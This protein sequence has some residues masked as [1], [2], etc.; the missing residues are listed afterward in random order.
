[1]LQGSSDPAELPQPAP[2][3]VV[4]RI[5][6]KPAFSMEKELTELE[7]TLKLQSDKPR[8]RI[9][10]FVVEPTSGRYVDLGAHE[11]Y[12]AAS[13]IKLPVLVTL[14]IA[15]DR[16]QVTPKQLLTVRQDLVAGG[17]GY[18]QWRA[19][20]SQV[21]LAEAAELMMVNSDNTATNLIIDLLGG[22]DVLNRQFAALGLKQTRINN[23]LPD[24]A[25]TNKTSPF[26]LAYLL[27]VADNGGLISED[28]KSFMFRLMERT[29]T[30]TLL[31]PGLGIGAK[32][33]HKTGDIGGMVGDA[34]IV[35]APSGLRYIVVGQV[36]RPHNDRRANEL[37]RTMSR[38]IYGAFVPD[39]TFPPEETKRAISHVHSRKH[40]HKHQRRRSL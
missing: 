31:P 38:T 30:R 3:T 23:L 19:V 9:G 32:I 15:M 25:G 10:L 27:A 34:G 2:Q 20:G 4:Q 21:S 13:M 33:A 28:G 35:T 11:S 7:T 1:M 26:D 14:L 18:L 36:E 17:S 37:I 39:A 6:V 16:K 8:L 12:A 24:F 29:R 40:G 22:A 5:N